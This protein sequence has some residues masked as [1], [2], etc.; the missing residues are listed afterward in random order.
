MDVVA[1]ATSNKEGAKKLAEQLCIPKAYGDYQAL[2]QDEQVQAV[3]ICTPN[4]LHYPMAKAAILAG[5]HVVCD[6]P[7][8]MTAAQ[9][10]ELR[11]LA[12]RQR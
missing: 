11:Q 4:Y 5:K 2:I 10:E 7:L 3:H 6:K 8:A 1:I 12:S 9:G